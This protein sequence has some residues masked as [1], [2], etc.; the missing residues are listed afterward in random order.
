MFILK[1]LLNL[2]KSLYR[3]K[4]DT[5]YQMLKSQ[6]TYNKNLCRVGQFNQMCFEFRF[7]NV[8]EAGKGWESEVVDGFE[9]VREVFEVYSEFDRK[10]VKLLHRCDMLK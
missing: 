2:S 7:S 5:K 4:Q 6:Y 8:E 10:P 9:G 3:Y 1:H